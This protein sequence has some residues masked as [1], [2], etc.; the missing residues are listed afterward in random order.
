AHGL[1]PARALGGARW[2]GDRAGRHSADQGR[3][4]ADQDQAQGS[5]RPQGAAQGQIDLRAPR[6]R[7]QADAGGG[8]RQGAEEAGEEARPGD[9]PLPRA[10]RLVRDR[11]GRAE[12]LADAGVNIA[13]LEL[14]AGRAKEPTN[15]RFPLNATPVNCSIGNEGN[16]TISIQD[17]GGKVDLNIGSED[18]LRALVLGLGGGEAA[19][20]A[21]LDFRDEDDN[22]R[23]AGAE[24]AEYLAAGR[25][26][27]PRNGPFL[28]VE[29]LAGV[30]ALTQADVDRISPLV[31]IYSGLNGIDTSVAPKSLMS[32]VA[33]GFERGGN[34]FE[35]EGVSGLERL[36]D[37][38]ALA[39]QFLASSTRRA[40]MVRSQ[41]RIAG[42]TTFVREATIEF[43]ASSTSAFVLRRW[44]RGAAEGAI[45][46]P[47]TRPPC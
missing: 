20:D 29:E 7:A 16:L 14:V 19:A 27:G 40:F 43:L 1:S 9:R 11:R 17:E 26:L 34:I 32:A 39:P 41:A 35:N 33:E 5:R 47:G 37:S 22:R 15:R 24:R 3:G 12:A 31:T 36:S 21:I 42:G 6:R 45:D 30:L 25:P 10:A 38:G 2:R 13:I 44:R 8:F 18:L 4:G 28:A 23:P 46:I